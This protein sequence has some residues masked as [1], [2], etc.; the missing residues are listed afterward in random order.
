MSATAYG[1]YGCIIWAEF[2]QTRTGHLEARTNIF[3]RPKAYSWEEQTGLKLGPMAQPYLT[4]ALALTDQRDLFLAERLSH[5][6]LFKLISD[7]LLHGL[8]R[9]HQSLVL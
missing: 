6:E 9:L 4:L 7:L 2:V 8:G 3:R 1:R 5:L